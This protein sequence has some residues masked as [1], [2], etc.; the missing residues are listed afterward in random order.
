LWEEQ[1]PASSCCGSKLALWFWAG[2]LYISKPLAKAVLGLKFPLV[3][4]AQQVAALESGPFLT[5]TLTA[6]TGLS[7][8]GVGP[9]KEMVDLRKEC[10][11]SWPKI[12]TTSQ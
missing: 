2:V 4:N 8:P 1:A 3:R 10:H 11:L 9:S 7:D 5:C 12:P 6:Q